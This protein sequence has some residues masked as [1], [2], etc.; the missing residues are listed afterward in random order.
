[1]RLSDER[2]PLRIRG[3]ADRSFEIL[4]GMQSPTGE[5]KY[6]F[7]Q[8]CLSFSFSL[9][10]SACHLSILTAC[11]K[12]FTWERKIV[13]LQLVASHVCLEVKQTEILAR[14]LCFRLPFSRVLPEI[15]PNR[16]SCKSKWR[17]DKADNKTDNATTELFRTKVWRNRYR[18]YPVLG[19]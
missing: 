11:L 4:R 7:P 14:I 9:F 8:F 2:K 13:E 17:P 18:R 12:S 6:C 3:V 19:K 1:M 15:T 10:F 5:N 16:Y